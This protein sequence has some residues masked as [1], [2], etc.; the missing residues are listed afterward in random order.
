MSRKPKIKPVIGDDITLAARRLRAGK[1]V[2]FPTET[3]YGIGALAADNK[4]VAKIYRAKNRPRSH[5]LIVHLPK[6]KDIQQWAADIPA[7]AARLIKAF[8]PGALTLVLPCGIDAP[9]IVCGGGDY[10]A[11]RIPAHPIARRLLKQTGA[12]IA[13]PSANRFGNL[14]A[15][16]AEDVAAEFANLDLYI[17]RGK[18]N[19]GI[20]SSIVGFYGG[21]PSLL[22]PGGITKKQ[23]RDVASIPFS[24]PPAFAR[25]PGMLPRHYAPKTPLVVV[26]PSRLPF[27]IKSINNPA[28]LSTRKPANIPPSMWRQASTDAN[29]Y[30]RDLYKLLREL[31]NTKAKKIIA[32]TPPP[33]T[34]WLA[35]RDR[36]TRAASQ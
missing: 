35:I 14:S 19:I 24:A 4:A 25:A 12:A 33:G 27:V 18:C 2:A 28:V 34:K 6:A 5:P 15:T 31:D 10:V 13:A 11:V 9:S 1:L 30:A 7:A 36:L 22:R 16:N 26:A 29:Q 21:R 20:E 3:V 8:M 32:T 23:L 17:L